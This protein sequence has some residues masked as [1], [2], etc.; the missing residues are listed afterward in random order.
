M[1]VYIEIGGSGPSPVA[2]PAQTTISTSLQTATSSYQ[3]IAGIQT[4]TRGSGTLIVLNS[5]TSTIAVSCTDRGTGDD[6][7]CRYVLS[8]QG[9]EFYLSP[10]HNIFIKTV[11]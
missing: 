10:S 9:R 5:E 3:T 4:G 6:A 8:G 11:S 7:T 2:L 1:T